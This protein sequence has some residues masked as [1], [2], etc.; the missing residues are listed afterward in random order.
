MLIRNHLI[1]MY[2]YI[3]MCFVKGFS[4]HGDVVQS[5]TWKEDGSQLAT[6]CKVSVMYMQYCNDYRRRLSKIL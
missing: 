6:G 2:M 5:V 3:P 1:F 4:E